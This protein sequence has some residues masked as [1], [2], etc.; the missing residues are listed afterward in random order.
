MYQF[1]K[2]IIEIIWQQKHFLELIWEV[3]LFKHALKIYLG[4]QLQSITNLPTFFIGVTIVSWQETP[5][6]LLQFW[7]GISPGCRRRE[8]RDQ[9][10]GMGHWTDPPRAQ[11]EIMAHPA[12]VG[13]GSDQWYGDPRHRPSPT[14]GVHASEPAGM[15]GCNA[16][17]LTTQLK[18]RTVLRIC[19]I[20]PETTEDDIRHTI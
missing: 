20:H 10:L 6:S 13:D 9:L 11:P 17:V 14:D 12:D 1:V 16:C 8:R 4:N 18:G 7:P 2:N 3:L 5:G 15:G 19:S